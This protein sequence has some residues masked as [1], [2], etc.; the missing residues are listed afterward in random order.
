MPYV[1][2]IDYKKL[3]ERHGKRCPACNKKKQARSF[4][5]S[6]SRYDGRQAYCR[7]CQNDRY[8]ESKRRYDQSPKGR[9]RKHRYNTSDKGRATLKRYRAPENQQIVQERRFDQQLIRAIE[10]NDRMY[11]YVQSLVGSTLSR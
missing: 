2:S 10:Q 5:R 9:A 3:V 7:T 1:K 4:N 11:P 6:T 8:R